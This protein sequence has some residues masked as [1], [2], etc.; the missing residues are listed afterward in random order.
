M[1]ICASVMSQRELI[2]YAEG[3]V[4]TAKYGKCR[5]LRFHRVYNSC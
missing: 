4:S 1:C 3:V 5:K 2:K